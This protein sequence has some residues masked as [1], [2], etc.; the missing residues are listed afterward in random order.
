MQ[1]GA[2]EIRRGHGAQQHNPAAMEAFK[3]SQRILDGGGAG[4][5]KLGPALLIV[6]FDGGSVLGER[7]AEAAETVHV[8]VGEVVDDLANGPTAG[9]I[10]GI[11]LFGGYADN[12]GVQAG[13]HLLD[14]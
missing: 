10:G 3:Q 13:G 14:A 5:E 12:G 1:K 7:E 6:T 2:G 4:I 9:A 8:T 11:E